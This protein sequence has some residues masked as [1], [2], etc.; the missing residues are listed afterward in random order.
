[1]L[2]LR[3]YMSKQ[4]KVIVAKF[5]GTSM[6]NAESIRRV[7]E[8]ISWDKPVITV[9][10]ATSGTT[11]VLEKLNNDAPNQTWN[12]TNKVI[13]ELHSKHVKIASDLGCGKDTEEKLA[14]LFEE[15]R[16][17]AHGMQMLKESPKAACDRLMSLGER[18]SSLLLACYLQEQV[19]SKIKL[20]DARTIITTNNDHGQAQPAYEVIAI[21]AQKELIPKIGKGTSYVTQGYIGRGHDGNTTTLGRGGS[22]FSAAIF[23]EAIDADELQIWTDV[24]GISSTDPRIVSVATPLTELT[25]GEAAELASAGAKILFPPTVIPTKRSNIPIRILNTFDPDN[26]GTY[27]RD[28]IKDKPLIRAIA[29]KRNQHLLTLSSPLMSEEYGFMSR[30]FN[31]FALYKINIDLITTS[32]TSVALTLGDEI[33]NHRQLFDDL[34]AIVDVKLEKDMCVVSIVG[35]RMNETP[36]VA[37]HIFGALGDS[38]D[39]INVRMI[40]QG[41]Y[42]HSMALVIDDKH[43]NSAIKALHKNLIEKRFYS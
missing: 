32:E 4:T 18:T 28:E 5:G 9:V 37:T 15:A 7:A 2:N 3:K 12:K 36:G 27:I 38:S 43:S 26:P 33:I 19:S 11:N 35:N 16:T 20:L 31:A 40:C 21:N 41:A 6:S 13:D 22:D 24:S 10:S 29:S 14:L 39:A 1:M 23:A 8:I 34:R 30:I 17:L 25:Y 42:R